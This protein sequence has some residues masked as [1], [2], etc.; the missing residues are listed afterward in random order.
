M[1][2]PKNSTVGS[3]RAPPMSPTATGPLVTLAHDA[4]TSYDKQASDIIANYRT[5]AAK[6]LFEL[7]TN[8]VKKDCKRLLKEIE[9]HGVRSDAIK[10]VVTSRLKGD[11]S[12]E[13][14]SPVLM[15]KVFP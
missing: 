8:D 15:G 6:H 4:S 5:K 2:Q 13:T 7:M 1:V 12:L 9:V 3:G 10:G 11:E 14:S